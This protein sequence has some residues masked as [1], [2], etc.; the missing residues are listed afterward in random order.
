M[1][2][3]S[4]DLV[5]YHLGQSATPSSLRVMRIKLRLGN[6]SRHPTQVRW[7][8]CLGFNPRLPAIVT[9]YQ[10]LL[11]ILPISVAFVLTEDDV[12]ITI[13]IIF[14]GE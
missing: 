13:R 14:D 10:R 5:P 11:P 1:Q 9:F 6:T 7:G 2:I 8:I 3:S 12:S 4:H